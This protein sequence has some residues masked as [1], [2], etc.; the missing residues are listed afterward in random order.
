ME[1]FVS[2]PGGAGPHPLICFL[3]GYDEAAPTPLHTALRR[4]GPLKEGNPP[5]VRERFIVLAPQLPH[6]GDVW[7]RHA[8][9]RACTSPAS[10][11]AAT[12]RV[13]KRDPDRPVWLSV[14]A[15]ARGQCARFVQV[16]RL[17]PDRDGA[18]V[19]TDDGDDHVG[20]ARRAYADARIY[21]WL[22]AF[23]GGA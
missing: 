4:H 12:T 22:L 7:Q 15:A 2:V 23:S 11:S 10:A 3:H 21:S 6:A 1:H 8:T 17:G 16:L 13:P 9:R 5:L 20:A 19:Y 14:G 18:R